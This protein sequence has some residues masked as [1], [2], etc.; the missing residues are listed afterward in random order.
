MD[1][2]LRAVMLSQ[3]DATQAA[4]AEWAVLALAAVEGSGELAALLDG[5]RGPLR[6]GAILSAVEEGRRVTAARG[7]ALPGLPRPEPVLGVG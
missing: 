2:S 1:E 7:P 3:L 4:E 6:H 5:G